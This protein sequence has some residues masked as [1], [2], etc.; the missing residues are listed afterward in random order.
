MDGWTHLPVKEAEDGG[1]Q[2]T[3]WGETVAQIYRTLAVCLL[4]DRL[5]TW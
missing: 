1:N 2:Q 5:L 3:L 4:I